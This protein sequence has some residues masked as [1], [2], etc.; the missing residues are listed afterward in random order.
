M[1]LTAIVTPFFDDYSIDYASL[2]NLLKI[3][4]ESNLDGI[5][6]LGST[7]ETIVLNETEQ[8]ELLNFI[9]DYKAKGSYNKQIFVGV[10]SSSTMEV[11]G[12]IKKYNALPIDGYLLC[13]PA[14]NKPQQ[15]GLVAHF[16]LCCQATDKAVILYNVPGRSGIN[17]APETYINVAKQVNNKLFIKEANDNSTHIYKVFQAIRNSGLDIQVL[18]G[19]DDMTP[20]FNQLGGKG[21][22][23]VLSNINPNEVVEITNGN[24]DTYFEY[25]PKMN[26]CFVQT[27]PVPIK[28]MLF[29][30]NIIVTNQVRLPLM[31]ME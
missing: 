19:N 22:V 2:S 25:L 16:T 18:S 21:V 3:Q 29:Q 26:D 13:T 17:V 1:T 9:L 4:F 31:R 23:S 20:F 28:N 5:V 12:R 7:A 8:E 15:A 30:A 10:S 14:Y 27:N 24:L 11:L 6:A